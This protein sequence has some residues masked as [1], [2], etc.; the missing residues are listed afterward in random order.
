MRQ[1]IAR[2]DYKITIR[3]DSHNKGTWL[4]DSNADEDIPLFEES[5]HAEFVSAQEHD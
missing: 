3:G 4:E 1:S 2:P 5:M